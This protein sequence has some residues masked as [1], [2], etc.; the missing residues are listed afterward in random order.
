MATKAATA[1]KAAATTGK[2]A[3]APTPAN[4]KGKATAPAP[5]A[6]AAPLYVLGPWPVRSQGGN[7]IRAYAY[8]VAKD[9]T[10]AQPQGFTLAQY[11]AALVANAEGSTYTQPSAGWSGHNMPTWAAHEKQGWLSPVPAKAS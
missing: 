7:T 9:L 2:A 11:K 6:P 4:T 3:P 5:A 1:T 8:N 10:K